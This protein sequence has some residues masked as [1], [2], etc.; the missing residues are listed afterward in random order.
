MKSLVDAD[1]VFSLI[2]QRMDA[3]DI[4]IQNIKDIENIK[5][6]LMDTLEN[7]IREI[8]I[9]LF[10][11][12]DRLN[13]NLKES[14]LGSVV[15]ELQKNQPRIFGDNGFGVLNYVNLKRDQMGGIVNY[16]FN[17]NIRYFSCVYADL[18]I[19]LRDVTKRVSIEFHSSYGVMN[20]GDF[21]LDYFNLSISP[22]AGDEKFGKINPLFIISKYTSLFESYPIIIG[23]KKMD[24]K[25]PVKILCAK[26]P[27]I[28]DHIVFS[29]MN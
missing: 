26:I 5:N 28:F 25:S 29:R 19:S 9:D 23:G 6:Q 24:L 17:D 7:Y 12:I 4:L 14:G 16:S 27:E 15:L 13:Q 2:K 10:L 1:N 20:W 3:A 22:D 11:F 21:V 18:Y 8:N